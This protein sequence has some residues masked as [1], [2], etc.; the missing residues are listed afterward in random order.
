VGLLLTILTG[1]AA[2]VPCG[3][4]LHIESYSSVAPLKKLL[5]EIKPEL[6]NEVY[7][8]NGQKILVGKEINSALRSGLLYGFGHI[9]VTPNA[10][11]ADV[12]CDYLLQVELENQ[13]IDVGF[14]SFST[15]TVQLKFKY[16]LTDLMVKTVKTELITESKGED[17]AIFIPI[18]LVA[19]GLYSESI[20]KAWD[21]AMSGSVELCK[22]RELTGRCDLPTEK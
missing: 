5:I 15:N 7:A 22:K 9:Y 14:W 21:K 11:I 10:Q 3:K 16:I 12:K 13:D 8:S 20:G 19:M 2:T 18:P 17:S 4:N 1:C 6:A